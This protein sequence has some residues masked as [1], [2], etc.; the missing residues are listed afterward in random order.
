MK[1]ITNLFGNEDSTVVKEVTDE[2]KDFIGKL[3]EVD[4]RIKIAIRNDEIHKT[5]YERLETHLNS[6]SKEHKDLIP[7]IKK[8]VLRYQGLESNEVKVSD[9][10]GI[11]EW[12]DMSVNDKKSKED[13][14]NPKGQYIDLRLNEVIN[15]YLMARDL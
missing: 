5:I 1:D 9:F 2:V 11:M 4:F 12:F 8:Q 10:L 14:W 7:K 6:I 3:C 13:Y 15:F